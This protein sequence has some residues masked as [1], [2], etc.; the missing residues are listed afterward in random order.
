M[1]GQAEYRHRHGT[2]LHAGGHQAHGSR[3][4]STKNDLFQKVIYLDRGHF[5]AFFDAIHPLK[6]KGIVGMTGC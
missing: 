1:Q 4:V 2:D 3:K 6:S 5:L